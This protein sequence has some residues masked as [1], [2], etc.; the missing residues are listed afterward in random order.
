MAQTF[1][2]RRVVLYIAS[3]PFDLLVWTWVLLVRVLWGT[4]L[5]WTEGALW[6]ELRPESWPSRTWYRY[7]PGGKPQKNPENKVKTHGVWRTWG[8]T[9]LGHGG[10]Y[11]PGVTGGEEKDT[12]VEFH[13]HIH[14]E[15]YEVFSLMGFMI[16]IL[17]SSVL[18]AHELW[19][20]G[21]VLGGVLWFLGGGAGFLS[22]WLTALL[23]GEEAYR[24]S[25][26]EKHAVAQA[27]DLVMDYMKQQRGE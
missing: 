22:G 5:W 26:H 10:W 6:T 15:Q 1:P 8:G 3:L 16:A 27:Q 19:M 20:L 4:K 7:R 9:T 17:V 23:R 18:L 24:G 12:K 2:K 14:V 21:G 13:E 11:G 25:V